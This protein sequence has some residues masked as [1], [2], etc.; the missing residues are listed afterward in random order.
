MTPRAESRMASLWLAMALALSTVAY[1]V[2]EDLT[3]SGTYSS[4]A[5]RYELLTT[6]GNTFLAQTAG[7]RVGVAM[8]PAVE[9]DVNGT[10][11]ANRFIGPGMLPQGAI[12]MTAGGCPPGYIR[13]GDFDGLAI[14]GAGYGGASAQTHSHTDPG[15]THGVAP[16]V[17]AVVSVAPDHDHPGFDYQHTHQANGTL[18][19]DG[20]GAWQLDCNNCDHWVTGSWHS[21]NWSRPTGGVGWANP[22]GM[23]LAGTHTHTFTSPG[24]GSGVTSNPVSTADNNWPPYIDV[25][26]CEVP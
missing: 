11:K 14:S 13:A 19:A 20:S 5:G 24:F 8:A 18:L 15:H 4:P 21:H 26:F 22:V 23:N 3:H 17:A 25:V 9:L 7:T 16:V 12:I 6:T 10:L 1:A 2:A